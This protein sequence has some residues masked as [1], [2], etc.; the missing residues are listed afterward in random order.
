MAYETTK[1]IKN[2]EI[3]IDFENM[4]NI[5]DMLI[6]THNIPQDECDE[7]VN[8]LLDNFFYENETI[9]IYII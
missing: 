7:I 8:E 5:K 6:N 2:M 4:G 3:V 1:Q 9:K